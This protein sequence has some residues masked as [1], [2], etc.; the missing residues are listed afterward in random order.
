M[1]RRMQI[2]DPRQRNGTPRE[3]LR[4]LR[5]K[6]F[7]GNAS[8]ALVRESVR[9]AKELVKSKRRSVKFQLGGPHVAKPSRVSGEM[10]R[11][12]WEKQLFGK[13]AGH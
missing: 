10:V 7:R 2:P 5:S 1:G 13:L 8:G 11:G 3:E 6:Y 12:K 9:N 4:D